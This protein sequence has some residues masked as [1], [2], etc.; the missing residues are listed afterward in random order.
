MAVI[1]KSSMS[2]EQKREWEKLRRGS[3]P[4]PEGDLERCERAALQLREMLVDVPYYAERDSREGMRY[5][6][7]LLA[8][9]YPVG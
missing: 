9:E 8:G 5:W 3:R 1:R 6:R 2:A 7:T 4:I